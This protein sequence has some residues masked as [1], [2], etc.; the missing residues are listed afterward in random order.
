M[1][2]IVKHTYNRKYEQDYH[3]HQCYHEEGSGDGQ[4][5]PKSHTTYQPTAPWGG[6]EQ[7]QQHTIQLTVKARQPA[8]SS[9][10]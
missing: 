1:L 7:Q 8:V 3:Y 10:A 6:K 5:M 4:E 9:R 2:V